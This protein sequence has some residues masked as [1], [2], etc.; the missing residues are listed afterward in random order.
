M[1]EPKIQIAATIDSGIGDWPTRQDDKIYSLDGISPTIAIAR[2]NH[3][4]KI[5]QIGSCSP[6]SACNAKVLDTDGI[7]PT[8]L[9]H[10]GAEPATLTPIRTEEQRQL[11][12]Q[13]IDTFGGR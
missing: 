12:K 5:M 7:C 13:G 1:N 11:R 10:K 4:P 8:L 6:S 3:A 9:D 2:S